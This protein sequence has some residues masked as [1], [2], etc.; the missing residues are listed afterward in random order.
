[1]NQGSVAV[2]M[3]AGG[4]IAAGCAAVAASTLSA[5]PA[6]LAFPAAAA[7]Y[8]AY[9][10]CRAGIEQER[11]RAQQISELH[12][13]TIEALALAIDAKDQTEPNHIQRVQGYATG[14]ARALGMPE[15][16]V[17]AVKTAA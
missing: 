11:G 13:A 3:Y 5:S 6:W 12:L 9:R 2:R 4:A 1:M 15:T 16:E 14:L 8:L 17:Q 10:A 7:I